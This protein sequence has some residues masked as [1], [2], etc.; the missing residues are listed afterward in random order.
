MSH[1][2][3]SD[4][5]E[6]YQQCPRKAFLLLRGNPE[7]HPHDYE[8]IVAERAVKKRIALALR[9]PV[10]ISAADLQSTFDAVTHGKKRGN[11][12]HIW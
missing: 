5:V 9:K 8:T 7:P 11:E 6:A 4:L 2:I 12:N 3:T 10:V 1:L